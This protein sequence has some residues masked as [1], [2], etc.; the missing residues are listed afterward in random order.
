MG[1]V[2][3]LSGEAGHWEVTFAARAQRTHDGGCVYAVGILL[4][5][6][7]PAQCV[8]P[9]D[10]AYTAV[11]PLAPRRHGRGEA[12]QAGNVVGALWLCAGGGRSRC[13][14]RCSRSP[15]LIMLPSLTLTPQRQKQKT[16]EAL[17][18]WILKE[19]ESQPVCF[20]ME[21]LHWIDPS[22]LGIPQPAD[23]SGAYGPRALSS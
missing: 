10:R 17:L 14:P 7:L 4:F 8:I 11:P 15:A 19:A 1:Q 21:D 20:I 5:A 22:T 23:Q 2:L 12:A 9:R 6:L 18:T 13:S 16:L 3:L